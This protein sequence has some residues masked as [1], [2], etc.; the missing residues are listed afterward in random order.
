MSD[1][2]TTLNVRCQNCST[3]N[4]GGKEFCTE[5]GT[6]LWLDC[7]SCSQRVSVSEKFCGKCGSNIRSWFED[8]AS[9]VHDRIEKL[10]EFQKKGDFA[11]AMRIC[12]SV[13]SSPPER[14]AKEIE[15]AKQRLVDLQGLH[16]RAEIRVE[17]D[18]KVAKEKFD[19]KEFES[20][21][22]LLLKI[23]EPLK[24]EEV[25]SLVQSCQNAIAEIH[26]LRAEL[27]ELIKSKP[28]D[29][30]PLIARLLTLQPNDLK[31]RKLG[32]QLRD[33]ICKKSLAYLEAERFADAAKFVR[34]VPDEFETELVQKV[35]TRCEE[36]LWIERYLKQSPIVDEN[37]VACSMRYAK[38]AAKNP[39]AKGWLEQANHRWQES[40][41]NNTVAAWASSKDVP[42]VGASVSVY[43]P[44]QGFSQGDFRVPGGCFG[45]QRLSVALGLAVQAVG[46]GAMDRLF[47]GE[48]KGLISKL[49]LK[50]KPPTEAWGIDIGVASI[51]AVKVSRRG[52]DISIQDVRVLE[53]PVAAPQ[54]RSEIEEREAIR[55]ALT[56]LRDDAS[57]KGEPCLFSISSSQV[58]ARFM[59]FPSV[60]DKKFVAM[61][62]AEAQHSI[63]FPL[64]DVEWY[65]HRFSTLD[66]GAVPV[67]VL[68]ARKDQINERLQLLKLLEFNVLGL[69]CDAVALYQLLRFQQQQGE[70][71]PSDTPQVLVDIGAESTQM[72]LVNQDRFWF[73]ATSQGGSQMTTAISR[74]LKLPFG[75]AEKVKLQPFGSPH[76]LALGE[77]VEKP[78]QD[79][80][81]E[82]DRSCSAS[83]KEGFVVDE[84]SLFVTGGGVRSLGLLRAL[85][86]P[87]DDG[88]AV[89]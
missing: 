40:K 79:M 54:T 4:P 66:S 59:R 10:K 25:Q 3:E 7:P 50:A 46:K 70:A 88:D 31:Y 48:K 71:G 75:E 77:A 43:Q 27:P 28:I 6:S 45:H 67:A 32:E 1:A 30:F 64:S 19:L 80:V 2:P 62:E 16:Q 24:T 68:T 53:L 52:D 38:L 61:V 35:K 69:Q 14:F 60:D 85:V 23:P 12:R 51:K 63:P 86:S 74:A 33:Q 17:Q 11:E 44:L 34:R 87:G 41:K 20:A 22:E 37:L 76:L 47:S 57:M 18:F 26:Q 8:E 21:R 82:I 83:R 81:G 84:A 58:L 42:V 89:V 29:A 49:G 78:V 15:F 13:M 5:C 56:K 72:V 39:N 55:G 73:R 65:W 9:K 36:A